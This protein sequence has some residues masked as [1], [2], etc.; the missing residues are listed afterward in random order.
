[1]PV[2]EGYKSAVEGVGNVCCGYGFRQGGV[3]RVGVERDGGGEVGGEVSGGG[4]CLRNIHV[5]E[6]DLW[7]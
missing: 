1:M 4:E 6:Q 5:D 7:L 2:L 3:G